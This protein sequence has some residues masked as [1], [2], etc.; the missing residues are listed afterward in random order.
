MQESIVSLLPVES[1]ACE[2]T[3]V[4]KLKARNWGIILCFENKKKKI[5]MTTN[6]YKNLDLKLE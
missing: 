3:V 1:K 5:A 2:A 6:C 4:Y